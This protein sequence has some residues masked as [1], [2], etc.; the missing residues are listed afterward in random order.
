M[1]DI[2]ERKI[3]IIVRNFAVFLFYPDISLGHYNFFPVSSLFRSTP[4][5][6]EILIFLVKAPINFADI[7]EK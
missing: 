3:I 7:R 2:D 6:H 4:C 5:E 1:L